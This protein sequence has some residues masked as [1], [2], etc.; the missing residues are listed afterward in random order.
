MPGF[1]IIPGTAW[2][3]RP[4]A[5]Y[6]RPLVWPQARKGFYKQPPDQFQGRWVDSGGGSAQRLISYEEREYRWSVPTSGSDLDPPNKAIF[7]PNAD[8]GFSELGT[9]QISSARY[10]PAGTYEATPEGA[11]RISVPDPSTTGV[12]F[13]S[14]SFHIPWSPPYAPGDPS[15]NPHKHVYLKWP[16]FDCSL[17]GWPETVIHGAL[18]YGGEEQ[19]ITVDPN[20]LL[21]SQLA[22]G[23]DF[24]A[25]HFRQFYAE[26]AEEFEDA[27][28]NTV[29]KE[30]LRLHFIYSISYTYEEVAGPPPDPIPKE[31]VDLSGY[32]FSDIL[33]H[34]SVGLPGTFVAPNLS[35]YSRLCW[36]GGGIVKL[37]G[38]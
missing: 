2:D 5:E 6:T 32:S 1:T 3:V 23:V 29:F 31:Y 34:K 16:S 20:S 21:L 18:S 30:L 11:G 36:A 26:E 19:G 35:R 12:E 15:R 28:D 8:S 27:L 17:V 4:L 37:T 24:R 14:F 25:E 7:G 22:D 38:S 10:I 33:Y 9:A 13:G